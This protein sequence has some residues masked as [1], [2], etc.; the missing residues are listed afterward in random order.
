[1]PNT[2]DGRDGPIKLWRA[3]RAV[4]T[5]VR[6]VWALYAALSCDIDKAFSGRSPPKR[7]GAQKILPSVAAYDAA[8][9]TRK[10]LYRFTRCLRISRTILEGTQTRSFYAGIHPKHIGCQVPP[11]A[12][13][14]TDPQELP[15][16]C[17]CIWHASCGA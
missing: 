15:L 12:V 9:S 16:A 3:S 14:D 11:R 17:R 4:M 13:Y 10:R 1:M 7:E 5:A 8:L 2:S 6:A